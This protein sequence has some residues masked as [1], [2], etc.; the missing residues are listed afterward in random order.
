M[1][2]FLLTIL[3]AASLSMATAQTPDYKWAIGLSG[4]LSEYSGDM[5][6]DFFK[7]H[8]WPN[9]T[10]SNNNI[11]TQE[12]RSAFGMLNVA[13]Y[14]NS[15]FDVN[16][17][18]TY[19]N[20][21][22]FRDINYAFYDKFHMA[23]LTGRWKFIGKDNARV[24]PYFLLGV[25]MRNVQLPWVNDTNDY[26]KRRM[27]NLTVPLGIGVNIKLE[28]RVYL[29][30]QSNYGWTNGDKIEG[31]KVYERLTYDQFWHH[32]IGVSVL[33]GK[34]KDADGD[35]VGDGKDK[36]PGTP[37]GALVDKTGCIVD[38][39]KDGIADNQDACPTV[40][41]LGSFKGCPDSDNDGVEDAKDKCPNVAG[42]AKF[43][44]CP[45]KDNDGIQD[46]E[47]KC[48]DI[49]GV[50]SLQGCPDAD[51]D[52][53]TDANDKCPRLA[54]T[55]ANEGCPD[56]DGDGLPDHKDKCPSVA[57]IEANNGCPEVKAQVKKLFERALQ[58]VQFESGKA[59]LKKE[60][61]SIL[62][63]VAKAMIENPSYKLF[64]GGHT[65]NSGNSDKNLQLSKDRAAAVKDYLV[66]KGVDGSRM[67]SE[68]Y[69]DTQPVADN[70]TKEGK[71]KNR[72][73]EFKVQFEDFVK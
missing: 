13:R 15:N 60:S 30:I 47:D 8:L 58:G 65:D 44:G 9:R 42:L 73:V 46:S 29:N 45:D 72:R 10:Y 12:S 59:T 21:G 70:A 27:T 52:G 4:G 51:G 3:G 23:D 50:A 26:N 38:A 71:A 63:A 43:D 49:A 61:N 32:S 22:Y 16:L 55:A 31:K 36:C 2:K 62:D 1:R 35:G 39:D 57:G 56:S 25:G 37:A 20:H 33:L 19:G 41:G 40:A 18:Y 28:E 6:N 53:I 14:L 64:V 34:M 48:P 68:G 66:K 17:A 69:G 67:Q 5:G 24:T 54:G 11:T 7:F